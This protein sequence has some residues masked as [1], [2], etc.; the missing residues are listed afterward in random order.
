MIG[1]ALASLGPK[2][3]QQVLEVQMLELRLYQDNYTAV[4]TCC[5]VIAGFAFGALTTLLEVDVATLDWPQMCLS[6]FTVLT[7]GFSFHSLVLGSTC[8]LFGYNLAWRGKKKSCVKNAVKV[9][10]D[11]QWQVYGTFGLSILCFQIQAM[12]LVINV[13]PDNKIFCYALALVIF[14]FLVGTSYFTLKIIRKF[15]LGYVTE[16]DEEN[17][18]HVAV[19][20][21]RQKSVAEIASFTCHNCEIKVSANAEKCT[22]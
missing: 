21:V 18:D 7:V 22:K 10:H 3:Q 15:Q 16:T 4:I 5:S 17:E 19:D 2:Q 11:S 8:N 9:M 6:L 12:F 13:W 1:A 20:T 14:C